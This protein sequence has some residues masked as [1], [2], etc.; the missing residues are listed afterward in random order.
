MQVNAV[1]CDHAAIGDGKMYISGG[2]WN[3]VNVPHVPTDDNPAKVDHMAIAV[4]VHVPYTETNR[5]HTIKLHLVHEDSEDPLPIGHGPAAPGG[6]PQVMTELGGEFAVGR[7]PTM[8]AGSEQIVPVPFTFNAL[9]LP[10]PGGYSFVL[11]IDDEE[12]QRL[13]WRVE[14]QQIVMPGMVA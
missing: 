14:V 10:R 5:R 4:L 9:P 1:L 8:T 2:G 12:V 11:R 13:M 6:E 7:P 3:Q